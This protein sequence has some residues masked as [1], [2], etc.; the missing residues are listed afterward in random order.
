MCPRFST[1]EKA[2]EDDFF[3][4]LTDATF[5]LFSIRESFHTSAEPKN[6]QGFSSELVGGLNLSFGPFQ[7]QRKGFPWAQLKSH[8]PN[9]FPL[10]LHNALR[11][12]FFFLSHL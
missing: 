7:P 9:F 6:Q 8:H 4:P 12:I 11:W 3:F 10:R 2:T 1:S 5:F